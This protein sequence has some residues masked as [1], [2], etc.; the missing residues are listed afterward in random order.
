[1]GKRQRRGTVETVL[2]VTQA[3]ETKLLE[4]EKGKEWYFI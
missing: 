4:A 1:M 2:Q 3:Y